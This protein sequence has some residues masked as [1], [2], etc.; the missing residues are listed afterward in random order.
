[1]FW[2]G[3][4]LYRAAFFA[5]ALAGC[6][7][8]FPV[9]GGAG[10]LQAADDL[11][12]SAL[13][14]DEQRVLQTIEAGDVLA[15]V[16]FLASDELA[17]RDTPSKELE[18]ASAYVASRFRGAGLEGLAANGSFYQVQEMPRYF[19]P[20]GPVS[21][22]TAASPQGLEGCVALGGGDAAVE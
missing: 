21:L 4:G 13:T 14:A 3:T 6:C 18:I 20:D 12:V 5:G 15:T 17:G 2:L 8:Q 16:S 19:A 22:V 11:T 9:I 1:M 10:A 7:G